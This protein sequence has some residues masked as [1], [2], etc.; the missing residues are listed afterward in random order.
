MLCRGQSKLQPKSISTTTTTK[1]SKLNEISGLKASSL[2]LSSHAH[3]SGHGSPEPWNA[4]PRTPPR[5]EAS[6]GT[7]NDSRDNGQAQKRTWQVDPLVF[8]G[9]ICPG[10]PPHLQK[11]IANSA[12]LR[13]L[14]LGR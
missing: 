5:P 13:P 14:W 7:L 6:A 8:V 3:S 12:L 2:P 11:I 9:P 4:D 1:P 10:L